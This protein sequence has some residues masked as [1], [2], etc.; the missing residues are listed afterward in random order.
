MRAPP[1]KTA[2]QAHAR[3]D[4]AHPGN[5][6]GSFPSSSFSRLESGLAALEALVD[7][8]PVCRQRYQSLYDARQ[9][10]ERCVGEWGRQLLTCAHGAMCAC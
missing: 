2:L 4:A 3:V 8:E 9:L 7:V 10:F 5:S 1:S 6:E